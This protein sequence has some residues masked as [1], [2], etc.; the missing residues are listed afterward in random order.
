MGC[1]QSTP[2]VDDTT[3]KANAA[4]PRKKGIGATE[5]LINTELFKAGLEVPKVNASGHL[6]QEEV[7]KRTQSSVT[8]TDVLLGNYQK[9]HLVHINYAHWTQRGYYPDG[10]CDDE[11]WGALVM[12]I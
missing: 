2:V 5:R 9:G 8:N 7:V 6:L 11:T 1:E 12:Q 4:P 10:M 3:T